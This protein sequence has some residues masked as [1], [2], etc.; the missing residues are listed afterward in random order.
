MGGAHEPAMP[1]R[2]HARTHQNLVSPCRARWDVS[3]EHKHKHR[4]TKHAHTGASSSIHGQRTPVLKYLHPREMPTTFPQ[5]TRTRY[6]RPS[7]RP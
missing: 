1:S 3:T 6:T 7:F 5:Q 2:K 4:H